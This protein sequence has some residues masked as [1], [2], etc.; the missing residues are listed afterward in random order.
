MNDIKIFKNRGNVKLT[1]GN[2]W[3]V[4]LLYALPLFGSAFVQQVYSLV[5][6]LVAGNYAADGARG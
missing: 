4:L 1:D 3:K 6:L 5:D 2:V